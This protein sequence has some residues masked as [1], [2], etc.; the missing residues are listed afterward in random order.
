MSAIH[1]RLT[2]PMTVRS[3][4]TDMASRFERSTPAQS[5]TSRSQKTFGLLS[6]LPANRIR[7]GNF[8]FC[9]RAASSSTSNSPA[10]IHIEI[11]QTFT[12]LTRAT[13]LQHCV[14]MHVNR[15]GGLTIAVSENKFITQIAARTVLSNDG[16]SVLVPI[17]Q[18]IAGCDAVRI[19]GFFEAHGF[20][21]R[22]WD[23]VRTDSLT[24]DSVNGAAAALHAAV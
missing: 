15:L 24:I 14:M 12:G 6:S 7:N 20:M 8:D 10:I 3:I 22:D 5:V 2:A 11:A 9:R 1:L 13:H 23:K 4:S 19:R 17:L 21:L 16:L 18:D